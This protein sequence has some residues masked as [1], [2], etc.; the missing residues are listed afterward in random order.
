MNLDFFI[1]LVYMS[2]VSFAVAFLAYGLVVRVCGKEGFFSRMCQVLLVPAAVVGFDFTALVFE[3][4]R[5]YIGAIPLGIIALILFYVRFV[6][7]ESLGGEAAP[8]E[9]APLTRAEKKFSKKSQRIHAA[10][11]S[12]G[13]D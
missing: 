1:F 12:R 3:E 7:G 4:Y 2:V 10:R 13:R 9:Q 5:Y 11:K 6:K 8:T